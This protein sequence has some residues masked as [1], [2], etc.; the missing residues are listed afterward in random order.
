MSGTTKRHAI[1]GRSPRGAPAG[2]SSLLRDRVADGVLALLLSA[3]TYTVYH[4]TAGPGI[5]H[6]SAQP[7]FVLLASAMLHGRLW[8]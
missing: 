4:W 1:S 5:N 6:Q 3:L 2:R 8:L 7:H